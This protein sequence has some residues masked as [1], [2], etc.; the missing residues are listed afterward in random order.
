VRVLVLLLFLLL[1]LLLLLLLKLLLLLLLVGVVLLVGMVVVLCR[2]V[3]DDGGCGLGHGG[4]LRG[5]RCG[6]CRGRRGLRRRQ[7][8]LVAHHLWWRWPMLLWLLL[9]LL[10]DG[11]RGVQRVGRGLARRCVGVEAVL[12]RR[13][14]SP[15]RGRIAA[16]AAAGHAAGQAG[17]WVGGD[18]EW[19]ALDSLP[20][21][22]LRVR[23][24]VLVSVLL[25]GVRIRVHRCYARVVLVRNEVAVVRKAAGSLEDLHT[26]MLL[27]LLLKRWLVEGGG[28]VEVGGAVG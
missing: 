25:R 14:A 11:A 28:V 9:L 2:H 15:G 20:G 13:G 26:R 21:H 23:V 19:E 27:L 6:R 8:G 3:L 16:R 12:L 1:L 18:L 5:H 10:L 24:V 17:I 4:L 7:L 22:L